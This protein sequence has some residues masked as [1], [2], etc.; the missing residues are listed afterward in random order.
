MDT[1]DSDALGSIIAS[2]MTNPDRLPDVMRAVSEGTLFVPSGSAY[3]NGRGT[4][5][6]ILF[7]RAG[8]TYMAVF[9]SQDK[10]LSVTPPAVYTAA[11]RGRDVFKSVR[12]GLGVVVN[13]GYRN[14]MEL[15]PDAVQRLANESSE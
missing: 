2:G 15:D 12:G 14:G 13:P 1:P 5:Q 7:E 8:V 11:M 10:V 3:D 4:F 9:T 6:P